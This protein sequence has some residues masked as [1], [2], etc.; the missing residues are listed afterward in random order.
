MILGQLFYFN[1]LLDELTLP[2]EV[3]KIGQVELMGVPKL[4]KRDFE[5][6][7]YEEM[8]RSIRDIFSEQYQIVLK[9]NNLKFASGIWELLQSPT[10]NFVEK[11]NPQTEFQNNIYN[12][13]KDG[14][15][16]ESIPD[17]IFMSK[18]AT[19]ETDLALRYGLK[20]MYTFS[21]NTALDDTL[22]I[23]D[24]IKFEK[25]DSQSSV[26]KS[27]IL[28]VVSDYLSPLFKNIGCLTIPVNESDSKSAT[29]IDNFLKKHE[30]VKLV[31]VSDEYTSL[32]PFLQ[33]KNIP[34]VLITTIN[35]DGQSSGGFF[36]R[37]T[38]KTLGVRLT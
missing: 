15:A 7:K 30:S 38:K 18:L 14:F 12:W 6:L 37:I 32:V 24:L 27:Q 13:M 21:A 20:V 4:D 1:K 8:F 34:D 26:H 35:I 28:V 33:K 29:L 10:V 3:D 23:F 17:L 19:D 2:L 31:L 36:D 5:N 11:I 22:D 25:N 9:E 16:I